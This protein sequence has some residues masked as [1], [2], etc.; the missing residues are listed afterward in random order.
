MASII[1]F[2]VRIVTN[3]I[4][5][6]LITIVTLLF[7]SALISGAEIALFSLNTTQLK[8]IKEEK[9][10]RNTVLRK[11][12][13]T[14]QNLLATIIVTYNFISI[15]IIFL[16]ASV[17]SQLFVFET[18]SGGLLLF[19]QIVVLSFVLLIVGGILPKMY[20]AKKNYSFAL[21]IAIPLY[22]VAVI[23]RPFSFFLVRT[24]N[25]IQKKLKK[26]SA[27]ISIHDLSYALDL[28]SENMKEDKTILK[29]IV[30][31]STIDAKGIM[32]P[33]VDVVAVDI[34]TKFSDLLNV[35]V[36]SAYSRIP[37]FEETFD[38]IK[39][40]LYVKD[41]LPYITENDLFEW[42]K[43]IKEPYFV[44]ENKK[45]N[46]LLEDFQQKK[47]HMAIVIDEYGGTSGIV[48]L[49]D[50]LEEAVGDIKDEYD[51]EEKNFTKLDENNYIFEGK[52]LLNDFYKVLNIN[53]D[54]FSTDKGDA[55]TLAGLILELTGEIPKKNRII[56]YKQ[57]DFKVLGV[58]NRRIKQVKVT[59]K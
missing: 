32:T 19:S 42:Q 13:E 33:R 34:S 8:K 58:D 43:L 46:D 10:K 48:S 3:E 7:F 23:F 53:D 14:P 47:I 51:V 22:I 54:V 2:S 41:L 26:K 25:V 12:L 52:F 21:H 31:F 56:G 18:S 6:E 40:I 49:E 37:V 16:T 1:A 15:T 4:L 57:F 29:G 39:G 55:E 28:T 44:P 9:G 38:N 17:T 5:F 11:L 35:I 30:K 45:I 36:K 27:H 59:I 24:T 50:I 20:A